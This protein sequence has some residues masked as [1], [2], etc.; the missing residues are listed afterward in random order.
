MMIAMLEKAGCDSPAFDACCLMEDIGG[1]P[2]GHRYDDDFE[3]LGESVTQALLSAVSRRAKGEPLQYILGQWDFLSLTLDV[4][5]GVLIPRPDT[6]LLCEVVVERLRSVEAPDIL[7]LCAG[8]GCV[9]IGICSLRDGVKTTEVE[10]SDEALVYLRKNTARYPQYDVS[11]VQDDV[12]APKE[13][14]GVYDAVVSNPPYIPTADLD[15]LMREV[16]REPKMALD[17]D[18]DGLRFYRVL[19]SYW[20]RHLKA[21]GLLAVEIGIGQSEDVARL[22]VENGFQNITVH[23]DFGGIDR[24]VC[25]TL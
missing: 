8:S 24:V 3:V 10:L 15:G 13:T 20:K 17:G 14:Y 21:G 11:I 19:T 4:G 18:E 25:G 9:G 22:F 2:H 5:E 7:D 1:L 23:R 16:Q 6:E 12:C